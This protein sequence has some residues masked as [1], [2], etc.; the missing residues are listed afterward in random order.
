MPD[1]TDLHAKDETSDGSEQ[2][3]RNW[4][5]KPPSQGITFQI[6][7]GKQTKLTHE[8]HQQI[9]EF[10]N[11]L[12]KTD[13][14]AGIDVPCSEL[15]QCRARYSCEKGKCIPVTGDTTCFFNVTCRIAT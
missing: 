4:L 7:V 5:L 1:E 11:W 15:D 13:G 2:G 3:D 10:V 14:V 6:A 9:E 8:T 12:M